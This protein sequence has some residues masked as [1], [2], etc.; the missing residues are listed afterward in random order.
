MKILLEFSDLGYKVF[1]NFAIKLKEKIPSCEFYFEESAPFA[2]KFL[3][4]QKDIKYNFYSRKEFKP[5]NNLI[6]YKI[7]KEF[8]S[9]LN[10]KS[11]W[12]VIST[13]RTLGSA[14]LHGA[15]GYNN[16]FTSNKNL[17]LKYF[18]HQLDHID[19]MFKKIKPDIFFAAPVMGSI[20]TIIFDEICKKYETE[21]VVLNG[22]RIPDICS[23]SPS[24]KLNF[25]L[26]ENYS[27]R[28]ID[29]NLN[30][31]SKKTTECFEKLQKNI[32]DTNSDKRNSKLK[33]IYLE[34]FYQR[35]FYI[36]I[37]STFEIIKCL[38]IG[39]LRILREFY[40]K[41]LNFIKFFKLLLFKPLEKISFLVQN[42]YVSHPK[43]GKSL[44]TDQKYIFFPLQVQPEY[45]SN[46]LGPLW[47][48]TINL[49]ENLA[50][51]LPSDWI[52]Y[53]KEHPATLTDRLRSKNFYKKIKLIP[54]VEF[55][56]THLD[57][58]KIIQNAEI[59]VTTGYNSIAFDT[60]ILKKPLLEFN[61]NYWSKINLSSKCSDFDK[62]SESLLDEVNRYKNI[63]SEEK[64]RRIKCLIES[65]LK[66]SFT[67]N[68]TKLAF[69]NETGSEENQKMCGFEIAE[70]FVDYLNY[71]KLKLKNDN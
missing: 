32:C 40:E 16:E 43:F 33:K 18:S 52:V 13:D 20:Q 70:G 60:I 15:H 30:N 7:L 27:K 45:S 71:I 34:K 59:V 17:I 21:Y 54:N 22:T 37:F 24:Y 10:H 64:D 14:F 8:E 31:F 66:H 56:P 55:A 69:Y 61:T 5:K 48:D 57:S 36:F 67:L 19:Q 46:V 47:L 58:F 26:I 9:R 6:N 29:Q 23:F 53:V 35:F 11:L 4:N 2:N 28:I 68:Y 1:H 63:S 25:P 49:I 42:Y 51:N 41:K 65:V 38:T 50:K 12:R 62:L 44:N 3:L 39:N